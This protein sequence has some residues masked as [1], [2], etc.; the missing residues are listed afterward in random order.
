MLDSINA[1]RTE[2]TETGVSTDAEQTVAVRSGKGK[3]ASK[4]AKGGSKGKTGKPVPPP[5]RLTVSA[6]SGVDD[7]RTGDAQ[8]SGLPSVDIF[9]AIASKR[10]EA[11][12]SEDDYQE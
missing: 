4:G 12:E 8:T 5:P 2:P 7:Y 11:S 9:G 1:R 3:G 6:E 10:V